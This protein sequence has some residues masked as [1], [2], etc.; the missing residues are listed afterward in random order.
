[1]TCG[2]IHWTVWL[3]FSP[4]RRTLR[5]AVAVLDEHQLRDAGLQ[6]AD[7][8]VLSALG[9]RRA[10]APAIETAFRCRRSVL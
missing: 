4:P 10:G 9:I 1:M 8:R 2:S 6:T 3:L 7:G 5:Q